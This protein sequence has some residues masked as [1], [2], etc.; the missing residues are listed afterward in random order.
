M[1]NPLA[2]CYHR[3]MDTNITK[4][5]RASLSA[6][7]VCA[8]FVA[9]SPKYDWRDFRSSEAPYAVLFPGKPATHTRNI[10][11]GGANVN[12]QMAAAMTWMRICAR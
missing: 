10:N 4:V 11:L 6:V 12:M 3:T 1:A 5:I 2:A 9:C 7:L 8:A